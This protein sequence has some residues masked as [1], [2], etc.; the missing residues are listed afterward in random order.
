[1]LLSVVQNRIKNTSKQITL[2]DLNR[3]LDHLQED[4]SSFNQLV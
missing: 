1:V 3:A 4:R 2:Q